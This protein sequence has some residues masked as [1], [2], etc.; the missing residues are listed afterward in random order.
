MCAFACPAYLRA[1]A[2]RHLIV[3]HCPP[4]CPSLSTLYRQ[5]GISLSTLYRRAANLSPTL[6]F[7]KDTGA[8]PKQGHPGVCYAPG[9]VPGT[10]LLRRGCVYSCGAQNMRE[11]CLLWCVGLCMCTCVCLGVYLCVCALM[12]CPESCTATHSRYCAFHS[13]YCAFHECLAMPR[14]ARAACGVAHRPQSQRRRHEV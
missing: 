8:A 12:L 3:H 5:H 14:A 11:R 9:N 6:L 7:I 1:Q 2:A 4:H 13:R 10:A